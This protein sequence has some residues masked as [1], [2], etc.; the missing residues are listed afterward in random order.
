[1]GRLSS[2]T[3]EIADEI[4]RAIEDGQGLVAICNQDHM[5]CRKTVH[6][7]L[8]Q[9]EAFLHRYTRAKEV[10]C[11]AIAD[12]ALAEALVAKDA[13]LGR[14]HFDARRW[15]VGKLAPKKYGE[16]LSADVNAAI[17]GE[18]KYTK[19]VREIVDPPTKE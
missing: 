18:I 7:W 6:T 10:G 19:L 4:I 3:E 16:K 9:H 11:D 12:E 8:R 2:Y 14:L 1:M 13:P 5:P 15:Y 17:S